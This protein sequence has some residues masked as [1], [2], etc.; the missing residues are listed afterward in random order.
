[1]SALLLCVFLRAVDWDVLVFGGSEEGTWN[2]CLYVDVVCV[3]E[4]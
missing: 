3:V 4:N 2:H 1:M